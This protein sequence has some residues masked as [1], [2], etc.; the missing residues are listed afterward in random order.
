MAYGGRRGGRVSELIL[1]TFATCR[2]R[3]AKT[4][5][6]IHIR[7]R[8]NERFITIP[9]MQLFGNL[10]IAN[11]GLTILDI[12]LQSV[13]FRNGTAVVVGHSDYPCDQ[14]GIRVIGATLEK[15]GIVLDPRCNRLFIIRPCTIIVDD[16]TAI[17]SG[18]CFVDF[19]IIGQNI[20]FAFCHCGQTGN[21]EAI[22]ISI[23]SKSA[24][25]PINRIIIFIFQRERTLHIRSRGRGSV[26]QLILNIYFI[27]PAII[28]RNGNSIMD[29][30]FS[31][32]GFINGTGLID[33]D[34]LRVGYLD[35]DTAAGETDAAAI[36]KFFGRNFCFQAKGTIKRLVGVKIIVEM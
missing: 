3:V 13:T 19:N 7:D 30:R 11:D 14:V 28:R 16:V 35:G 24:F 15:K 10:D 36:A 9:A 34:I 18:I 17:H 26:M 33:P 32:Y 29:N 20:L 4:A 1:L 25:A 22:E 5:L 12:I 21:C 2:E 8:S 6:P 31:A 27:I 23:P